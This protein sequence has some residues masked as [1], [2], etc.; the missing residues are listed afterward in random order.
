MAIGGLIIGR[1]DKFLDIFRAR[2]FDFDD[3]AR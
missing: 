2:H 3:T 1:A